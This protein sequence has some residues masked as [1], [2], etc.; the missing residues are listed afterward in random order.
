MDLIVEWPGGLVQELPNVPPNRTVTL[1]EGMCLDVD[2]DGFCGGLDCDDADAEVHPDAVDRPG[3]QIDD[4]CDGLAVCDPATTWPGGRKFVR[5]VAYECRRLVRAGE[6]SRRECAQMVRGARLAAKLERKAA[7]LEKKAAKREKKD[8]K[9]RE[10][11][12]KHRS[13]IPD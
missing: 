3:D 7:R 2:E 4:D 5:C 13:K 9:H 10:K 6:V 12:P 1:Y 8:A 11:P